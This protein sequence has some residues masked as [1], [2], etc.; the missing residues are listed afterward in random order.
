MPLPER[1]FYSL[2]SL[3]KRWDCDVDDILEWCRM[4][5]LVPGIAHGDLELEVYSGPDTV[6]DQGG[7]FPLDQHTLIVRYVDVPGVLNL[8][9]FPL[10]MVGPI[11]TSSMLDLN[12]CWCRPSIAA[13]P[14]FV[15]NM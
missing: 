8:P 12:E 4:Q 7:G 14:S 2:P 3:A 15:T 11:G 10:H 9:M 5:L 1:E 6:P 13:G